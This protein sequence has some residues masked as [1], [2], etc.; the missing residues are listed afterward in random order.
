MPI[1]KWHQKMALGRMT[2]GRTAFRGMALGRIS[3]GNMTF[4]IIA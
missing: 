2:F 4:G 1:E 3:F